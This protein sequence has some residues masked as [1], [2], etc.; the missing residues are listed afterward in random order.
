MSLRGDPL[1]RKRLSVVIEE[2]GYDPE[3][4]ECCTE[5]VIELVVMSEM[6][7]FACGLLVLLFL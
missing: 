3:R 5:V 1:E 6:A 4:F 2:Q 7:D